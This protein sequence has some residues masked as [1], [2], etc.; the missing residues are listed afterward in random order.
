MAE[1]RLTEESSL[2]LVPCVFIYNCVFS[3]I[4]RKMKMRYA[5]FSSALESEGNY[6][7]PYKSSSCISLIFLESNVILAENSNLLNLLLVL[8]FIFEGHFY[9]QVKDGKS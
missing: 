8:S 7:R 6:W 5:L 4:I 1:E 2:F 3:L 9:I